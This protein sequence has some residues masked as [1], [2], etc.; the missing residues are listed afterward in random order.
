MTY[1][2]AA[3]R[4]IGDLPFIL[5]ADVGHTVPSFTMINGAVAELNYKRGKGKISFILK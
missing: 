1:E 2:E 3:E 5:E 4:A